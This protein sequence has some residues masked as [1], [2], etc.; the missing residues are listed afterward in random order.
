MRLLWQLREC[1]FLNS[2]DNTL[3]GLDS[4]EFLLLGGDF[5]C[6]EKAMDRNHVEPH[7]PSRRRLIELKNSNVL[8]DI[9]RNFHT[10]DKQYTW[11]HAY[12]NV[13]SL[14]RLD[15]FYGFKHQFSLFRN[16]SI[17][18]VGFQITV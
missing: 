16:C 5:N 2:L 6:T 18:P 12:N 9:W 11:V 14:A 7:M 15:R 8:V 10:I 17:T 13:L 3:R 1:F 4:Q